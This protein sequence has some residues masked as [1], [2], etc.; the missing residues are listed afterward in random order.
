MF[1][2]MPTADECHAQAIEM[3][4]ACETVDSLHRD[5][6]RMGD[7]GMKS[8]PYAESAHEAIGTEEETLR[9]LAQICN[10]LADD[11]FDRERQCIQ[12]N[13]D[14]AYYRW[15]KFVWNAAYA[16]WKQDPVTNPHPGLAPPIPPP[17]FPG[18]Q[19]G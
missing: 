6:A 1:S 18:A 10:E 2:D 3:V 7:C 16:A 9:A 13:E 15:R 14:M 8:G 4:G 12:Y 5:I 19:E 11:L 17:P